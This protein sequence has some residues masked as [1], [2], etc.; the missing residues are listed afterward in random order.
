[1]QANDGSMHR[2]VQR[3]ERQGSER[4]IQ[5]GLGCAC[6]E[7]MVDETLQCSERKGP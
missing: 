6:M 1:M 3:V 5:R 2:L 7:V 4:C